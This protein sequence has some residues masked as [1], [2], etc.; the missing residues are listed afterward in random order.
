MAA[1]SGV[2]PGGRGLL[3]GLAASLAAACGGPGPASLPPGFC[4]SITNVRFSPL[5]LDAPPGGS[6]T[7]LNDDGTAHSVTSEAAPAGGSGDGG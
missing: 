2:R 3:M 4:V 5:N 1:R 6:V 7:V